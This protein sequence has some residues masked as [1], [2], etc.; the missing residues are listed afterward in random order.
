MSIAKVKLDEST[1]LE[2]GVSITGADGTPEARFVIE[3][4]DFSIMYP[5]HKLDSGGI[6]VMIDELG[7]VIKAG[8]YPV[9]LEIVI[10]NKI[11]VPMRDT[12]IFEPNV[13]I[14]TKPKSVKQ[15]KESVKVDNVVVTVDT[16]KKE[17]QEKALKLAMLIAETL[18]YEANEDDAPS[19]IINESLANRVGT[20]PT[21]KKDLVLK[22][23]RAAKD[24]KIDFDRT[25][26][27]KK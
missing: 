25:L 10:E 24:Q 6:E 13:E 1:K 17:A 7:H 3:G 11:F 15:V 22:M 8:E 4:K 2:F 16:S 20:L 18:N 23:L 5:C 9:R 12:I 21:Q 27:G 26:L 14:V 19:T